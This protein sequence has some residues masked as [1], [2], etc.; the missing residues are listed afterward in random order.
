M[1]KTCQN[2]SIYLSC[3]IFSINCMFW[4]M[5]TVI[6]P[7][8]MELPEFIFCFIQRSSFQ[9]YFLKNRLAWLKDTMTWLCIFI[10]NDKVTDVIMW[11]F[12]YLFCKIAI[13]HKSEDISKTFLHPKAIHVHTRHTF[14]HNHSENCT[15]HR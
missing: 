13:L 1:I 3:I 5:S 9:G 7:M 12:V 4:S 2:I 15:C 6:A 11:S 8:R 14:G 10:V